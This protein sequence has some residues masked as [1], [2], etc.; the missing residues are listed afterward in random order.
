LTLT[1][2]DGTLNLLLGVN[3]GDREPL[4]DD[5]VIGGYRYRY[6]LGRLDILANASAPLDVDTDHETG[7]NTEEHRRNQN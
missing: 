1:R 3:S 6:F 4:V 5:P 2:T 7:N